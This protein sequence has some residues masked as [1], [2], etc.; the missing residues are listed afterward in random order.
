[1]IDVDDVYGTDPESSIT[2]LGS[3]FSAYHLG[4]VG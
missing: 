4:T 3:A 2:G 1:M